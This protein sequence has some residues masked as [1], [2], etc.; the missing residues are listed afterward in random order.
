MTFR[1]RTS[2]YGDDETYAEYGVASWTDLGALRS[3]VA[4]VARDAADQ[5]ATETRVF[6][7]ETVR[8]VSDAARVRAGFSDEP[9]FVLE[10]DLTGGS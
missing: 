5:G 4:A 9:D 6:I 7:P 1:T 10:T 8:H 2:S 3:L